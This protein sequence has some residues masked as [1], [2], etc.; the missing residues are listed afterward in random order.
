LLALHHAGAGPLAQLLDHRSSD[1]CHGGLPRIR[2]DV[3]PTRGRLAM[4]LEPTTGRLY[5]TP[6]YSAAGVCSAAGASSALA[7]FFA[8]ALRARRGL[9][10]SVD[11]ANSSS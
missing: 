11:S 4:G 9:S 10:P 6:G 5:G 1:V 8:G 2:V 7:A 3:E